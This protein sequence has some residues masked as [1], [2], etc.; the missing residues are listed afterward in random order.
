MRP[1]RWLPPPSSLV[2]AAAPNKPYE[3]EVFRAGGAGAG[4]VVASPSGTCGSCFICIILDGSP[5]CRGTPGARAAGC[6]RW[7]NVH[8]HPCDRLH[9]SWNLY[10]PDQAYRRGWLRRVLGEAL[11]QIDEQRAKLAFHQWSEGVK[12]GRTCYHIATLKSSRRCSP[13]QQN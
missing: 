9:R 4:P 3:L 13:C 5:P 12:T 8:R 1:T 2:L 6:V 7:L 11:H 10:D